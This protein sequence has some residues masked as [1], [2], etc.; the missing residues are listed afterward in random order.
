MLW[1]LLVKKERKKK[2]REKRGKGKVNLAAA[3]W[4]FYT[5]RGRPRGGEGRHSLLLLF[6]SGEDLLEI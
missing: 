6:I 3:G 2:E 4:P 1:I 5:L